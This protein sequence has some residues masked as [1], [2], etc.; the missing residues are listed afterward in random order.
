M[1]RL[2]RPSSLT[3]RDPVVLID[4]LVD[5]WS[6]TV[7]SD[8]VLA[9]YSM[10]PD[11][12]VVYR[13]VSTGFDDSTPSTFIVQEHHEASGIGRPLGGSPTGHVCGRECVSATPLI[14]PGSE[15][16]LNVFLMLLC[17]RH[18]REAGRCISLVMQASWAAIEDIRADARKI[19]P[20][21]YYSAREVRERHLPIVE[22]SSG[23]W[24]ML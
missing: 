7:S 1:L 5:A 2:K 19:Q 24:A 13:F 15:S 22:F 11:V 9:L 3:G 4:D 23:L 20:R 10:I 21:Y 12:S 8:G 18:R 16:A 14:H 17:H 6:N